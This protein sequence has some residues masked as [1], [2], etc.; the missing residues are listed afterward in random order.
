VAA[1]AQVVKHERRVVPAPFGDEV[2]TGL[3]FQ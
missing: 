1:T 2:I 3:Q